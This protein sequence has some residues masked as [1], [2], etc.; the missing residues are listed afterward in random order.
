MVRNDKNTQFCAVRAMLRIFRREAQYQVP[1][2]FP[3][4]IYQ[5]R[6]GSR[7]LLTHKQM[8][9]FIKSAAR[10]VYNIGHTGLQ[11]LGVH[12]LRVGAAVMLHAAGF[13]ADD[14]KFELRWRSDAFRDYLRNILCLATTKSLS[15]TNFDPDSV[16]F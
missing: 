14:I 4:A 6:S 10:T 7:K 12:S 9:L 13:T 8:E 11:K 5:S 3:L 2:N 1:A 15:L 16:D